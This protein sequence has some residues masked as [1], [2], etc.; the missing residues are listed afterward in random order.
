[1]IFCGGCFKFRLGFAFAVDTALA[2]S[3]RPPDQ[4][5]RIDSFVKP[6]CVAGISFV[7]LIRTEPVSAACR[8]IPKLILLVAAAMDRM[9]LGTQGMNDAQSS[10]DSLRREKVSVGRQAEPAGHELGSQD[11]ADG[12]GGELGAERGDT[13]ALAI[14]TGGTFVSMLRIRTSAERPRLLGG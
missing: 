6:R 12:H 14:T 11:Q 10:K 2:C 5:Q 13:Q 3:R 9:G 4:R 1:M 7:C 8:A